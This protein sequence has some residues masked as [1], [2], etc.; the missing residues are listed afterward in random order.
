MKILN[1]RLRRQIAKNKEKQKDALRA[2]PLFPVALQRFFNRYPEADPADPK[3][4]AFALFVMGLLALGSKPSSWWVDVN[5]RK[6]LL[7]YA[8]G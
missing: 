7:N 4:G 3:V 6:N 2:H 8:T 5:W 1:S